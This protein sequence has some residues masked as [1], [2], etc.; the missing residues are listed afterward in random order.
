M[1]KKEKIEKIVNGYLD[2]ELSFTSVDIS[3]DF[4]KSGD[5]VRNS[6]VSTILK[7]IINKTKSDYI[8]SNIKVK[9]AEDNNEVTAILYHLRTK[10]PQEYTNL[11]GKPMKPEDIIKSRKAGIKKYKDKFSKEIKAI[12]EQKKNAPI[13]K[14][15]EKLKVEVKKEIKTKEKFKKTEIKQNKSTRNYSLFNFINVR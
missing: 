8:M 4:K 1:K 7:D 14:Q 2:S 3:N 13:K 5:W 9:R 6:E 15:T 12:K 11:E 10:S